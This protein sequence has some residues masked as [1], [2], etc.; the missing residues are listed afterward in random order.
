MFFLGIL[1]IFQIFFIPGIILIKQI[2]FK[3]RLI[4]KLISIITSSLTINYCLVLCLTTFHLYKRSILMI[5]V[6]CE[7]AIL[8]WQNW[9]ELNRP[10]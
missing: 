6:C 10:I 3:T 8:I 5:I 4:T 2:G 1:S 9:N 7:I